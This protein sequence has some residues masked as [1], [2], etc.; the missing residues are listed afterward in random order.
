MFD[1]TIASLS[2]KGFGFI[3]SES[4]EEDVFFHLKALDANFKSLKVGQGVKFE[5]DAKSDRLRARSV[6][7]PGAPRNSQRRNQRPKG[8][9]NRRPQRE[10]QSTPAPPPK[11]AYGFVTRLHRRKL[12]GFISSDKGGPEYRFESVNVTGDKNYFEVEV[13]DYVRFEPIEDEDDPLNRSAKSIEVVERPVPKGSLQ[14]R[15][16]PKAQGKKPSWR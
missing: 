10:R 14:T 9:Q 16:H 6:I 11:V 2:E 12:A 4:H 8:P 5:V 3:Q 7:V 13:S 1:G 15:R